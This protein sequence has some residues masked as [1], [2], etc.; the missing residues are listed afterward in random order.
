M[1]AGRPTKYR[2]E[3][4]KEV[5]ELGKEGAS[6]HE[7]ALQLDI[8]YDTL[9]EWRKEKP[10]FSEAIKKAQANAQGWWEQKGRLATIGQVDN[11]NATA[12]IFN[13]KNRFKEDWRDK[14]EVENK[15]DLSD[16]L[17]DLFAEIATK[18][19]RIGG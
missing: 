19:K 13:M 9:N 11:F 15:H 10:E 12:F 2:A 16:P 18:G 7:I 14:Q 17:S 6:L 4:C 1:P 3:M 8:H 5:V